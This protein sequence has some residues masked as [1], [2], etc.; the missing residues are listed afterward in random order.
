MTS[1]LSEEPAVAAGRQ[2]ER[3][4]LSTIRLLDATAELIAEKGYERTTILDIG[5][6]AGYSHGLVTQRFGTKAGLMVALIERMTE[7]FGPEQ[8]AHTVGELVGAEGLSA[9]VRKI[10]ASIEQSPHQMRGFYALMFEAA[11]PHSELREHLRVL[12]DRHVQSLGDLAEAGV[13]GGSFVASESPREV[14]LHV[15]AAVRG[16]SYFWLLAPGEFDILASLETLADDIDRRYGPG[17][18]ADV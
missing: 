17:S 3:S 1:Q 15:A 8:I 7:R 4:R 16:M 14:A 13:S 11:N 12:N 2:A 9:A 18:H 5:R 10:R 6:R